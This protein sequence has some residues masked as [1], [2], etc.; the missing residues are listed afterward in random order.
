MSPIPIAL[1]FVA[2]FLS[3]M[4]LL[5]NPAHDLNNRVF[6]LFLFAAYTLLT[7]LYAK[8]MSTKAKLD[9]EYFKK[10]FEKVWKRVAYFMIFIHYAVA[11]VFKVLHLHMEWFYILGCVGYFLLAIK[12]VIAAS[13]ILSVFFVVS[14]YAKLKGN[15]Y[16]FDISYALSKSILAAYFISMFVYLR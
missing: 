10:S 14:T 7:F 16:G 15:L 3:A 6:E 13:A 2:Y 12:Q 8:D 1:P 5:F 9:K 11:I 4:V